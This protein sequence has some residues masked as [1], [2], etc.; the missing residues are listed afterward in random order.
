MSWFVLT[1]PPQMELKAAD[2]IRAHGAEVVCPIEH[3]YMRRNNIAVARAVAMLPRYL[4]VEPPQALDLYRYSALTD[5]AGKRLIVGAL[6]MNG[7]PS[8][9]PAI[10]VSYMRGLETDRPIVQPQRGLRAGDRV[11]INDGP[12]A[13]CVVTVARVYRG[14]VDVLINL[15]GS[16]REVPIDPAKLERAAA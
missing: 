16:L 5:R 6:G 7:M 11:I 9:V 2:A 10:S 8:P 3:K 14:K 4:L 1:T 12:Y 13:G 15:F